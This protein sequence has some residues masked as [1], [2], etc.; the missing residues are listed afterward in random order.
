MTGILPRLAG[1]MCLLF[2]VA[3]CTGAD[4]TFGF[5]KRQNDQEATSNAEFPQ[6][7]DPGAPGTTPGTAQP[8]AGPVSARVYFA[9]VVGAPV[10]LIQAMSRRLV[11]V[12]SANGVSLVAAGTPGMTH[13]IKGYFSAFTENGATTV[14]HV[15]DVVSPSGQRV[16]RIQGQESVPGATSDPWAS[17]TPEAMEAIAD[18]IMA[19]YVLWLRSAAQPAPQPPA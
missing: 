17:V 2:I 13:E 16:H 12:G 9:P 3:G 14:I 18:K 5:G 4:S 6:L 1:I 11:T 15:W 19:Q 8:A 7:S 10:E